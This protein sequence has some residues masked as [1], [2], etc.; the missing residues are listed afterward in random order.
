MNIIL[1]QNDKILRRVNNC[2]G[3]QYNMKGRYIM[4]T[5]FERTTVD[6]VEALI[7]V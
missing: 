6:D 1:M 2:K 5:K 7:N 4:E 3:Y